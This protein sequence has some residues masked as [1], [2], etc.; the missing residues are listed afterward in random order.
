MHWS[1]EI[2]RGH[3]QVSAMYIPHFSN[4]YLETSIKLI[5]NTINAACSASNR[6][7]SISF[8]SPIVRLRHL[9][10]ETKYNVDVKSYK[11]SMDFY[12]YDFDFT[13]TQQPCS[14][15]KVD[16]EEYDGSELSEQSEGFLFN[17][18]P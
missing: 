18:S 11:A 2:I 10:S 6:F 13:Q 3:S 7:V 4:I 1:Q 16:Q 14:F 5:K 9:L 17:I 8:H 15:I 12:F